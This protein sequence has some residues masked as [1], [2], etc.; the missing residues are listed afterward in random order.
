MG[1]EGLGGVYPILGLCTRFY[2]HDFRERSY[3]QNTYQYPGGIITNCPSHNGAGYVLGYNPT[4][5]LKYHCI[6]AVY[7]VFWSLQYTRA[8]RTYLDEVQAERRGS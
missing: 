6:F 7:I 5:R 2:N 3:G 4:R 1:S 8:F